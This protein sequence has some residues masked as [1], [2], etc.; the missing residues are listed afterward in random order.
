M[1]NFDGFT[2]AF[3]RTIALARSRAPDRIPVVGIGGAQGS[4]KTTLVKAYAAAHPGVAHF[5]IDDVYLAKAERVS[6]AERVHP[7]FATRGPPGT[8]DMALFNQ[9]LDCLTQPVEGRECPLPSFDK[10]A[11]DR[12]AAL[13]WTLYTRRPD[14]VLVEGWC[15]GAMPQDKDQLAEPVNALEAIEDPEGRWRKYANDR[16][17]GAYAEAFERID[18][19][20]YFRAP[21]FGVVHHW[22]GQQEEDLLNR[23]LDANDE[24]RIARFIQHFE[25]LTR[26]MMSGG[27]KA[28][29]VVQ[30]DEH[31]GVVG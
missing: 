15:I 9:T 8:H 18:A 13:D 2:A 27:V 19:T 17:K 14:L 11:D 4:G 22:R 25:R 26:H 21:S 20:L 7:L 29:V 31:R 12:R 6:L 1:T 10:L 23:P 30:L 16:L 5:S 28:D 24:A 3:E